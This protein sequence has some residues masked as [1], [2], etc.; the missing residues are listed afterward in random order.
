MPTR[1]AMFA[2]RDNFAECDA[3]H[4]RDCIECG[5][6]TFSCPSGIPIVHLVKY[7]KL[8]LSKPKKP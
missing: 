2:E 5:A 3:A 1:L 8:N 6:C 4:V 7:A